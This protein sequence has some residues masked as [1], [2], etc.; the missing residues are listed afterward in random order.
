[1]LKVARSMLDGR[2]KTMA[3]DKGEDAGRPDWER[4]ISEVR[5]GIAKLIKGGKEMPWQEVEEQLVGY[6][7]ERNML[8]ATYDGKFP[9]EKG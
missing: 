4:A 9:A 6:Q 5:N 1:M 2:K 7:Q 3:S 8:L